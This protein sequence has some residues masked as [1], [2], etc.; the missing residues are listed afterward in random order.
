MIGAKGRG[1]DHEGHDKPPMRLS[2]PNSEYQKADPRQRSPA[3]M[4][5][6][7]PITYRKQ[8]RSKEYDADGASTP[9]RNGLGGQQAL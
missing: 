8:Y 9:Q 5:G 2:L 7:T 6:N 4:P 3:S 1:R